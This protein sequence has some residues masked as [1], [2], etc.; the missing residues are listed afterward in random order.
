MTSVKQSSACSFAADLGEYRHF[1][2]KEIFE[3]PQSLPPLWKGLAADHVLPCLHGVSGA[4]ERLAQVDEVQSLLAEPVITRAWWGVTG[5][6]PY[7]YS[8]KWKSPANTVTVASRRAK[9]CCL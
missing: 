6:K 9:I 8:V 7:R 4:L 3:Q 5:L 1:M 2:L